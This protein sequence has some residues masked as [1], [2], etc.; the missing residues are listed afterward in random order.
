[1]ERELRD[2]CQQPFSAFR[3]SW[4]EVG[5]REYLQSALTRFDHKVTKVAGF[6]EVDR[7]YVYRLMR[8]H[9]LSG[10]GSGR[11]TESGDD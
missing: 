7:T 11:V 10:C 6:A 2:K 5:E 8:K 4:L 1:M 3:S 9:G